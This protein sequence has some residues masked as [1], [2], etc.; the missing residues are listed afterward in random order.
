MY[1]IWSRFLVYFQLHLVV[2]LVKTL[3]ASLKAIR[4]GIFDSLLYSPPTPTP[5]RPLRY[6]PRPRSVGMSGIGQLSVS[7]SISAYASLLLL[8]SAFM[9]NPYRRNVK[10]Y[11]HRKTRLDNPKRYPRGD[12]KKQTF[13]YAPPPRAARRHNRAQRPKPPAQST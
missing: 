10:N 12:L 2:T 7:P 11:R 1:L 3:E 13:I 6:A 8:P 5:L 9:S 4:K